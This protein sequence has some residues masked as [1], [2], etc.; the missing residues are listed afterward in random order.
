V[1]RALGLQ[2]NLLAELAKKPAA[3][4]GKPHGALGYA[5]TAV[6]LSTVLARETLARNEIAS[7]IAGVTVSVAGTGRAT[8]KKA[9]IARAVV[10]WCE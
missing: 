4:R 7:H 3:N 10:E 9:G 1:A 8:I 2:C 6:Q 5:L